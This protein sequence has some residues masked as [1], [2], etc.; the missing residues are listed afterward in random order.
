MDDD[1]LAQIMFRAVYGVRKIRSLCEAMR[2]GLVPDWA[3]SEAKMILESLD[4]RVLKPTWALPA[5]SLYNDPGW[6]NVVRAIEDGY[7]E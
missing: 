6:D 7:A 1:E 4:S 2:Q 3:M 5:R